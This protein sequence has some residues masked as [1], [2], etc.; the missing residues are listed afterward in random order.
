MFFSTW[1]FSNGATWIQMVQLQGVNSLFLLG[2]HWQA[3][4]ITL[5]PGRPS[6]SFLPPKFPPGGNPSFYRVNLRCSSEVFATPPRRGRVRGIPTTRPFLWPR[7]GWEVTAWH[8]SWQTGLVGWK[9]RG[10]TFSRNFGWLHSFW[11][12]EPQQNHWNL[13]EFSGNEHNGSF[14][15][16][17]FFVN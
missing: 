1:T 12:Q 2:F 6:G 11:A 9:L 15:V 14:H 3:R 7:D 8:V 16:A 4:I 5:T 10:E 13:M 17:P